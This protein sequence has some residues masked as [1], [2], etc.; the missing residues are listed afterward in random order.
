MTKITESARG[1]E[2]QFRIPGVCNRNPETTV[3]CHDSGAGFG[4]KWADT[5]GGYGCSACHDLIDGR[6][7]Y[8]HNGHLV[9]TPDDIELMFYQGCRRTRQI[10]IKKGLI[11]LS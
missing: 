11:K 3:F 7:K 5:E 9:Y 10:L 1:E 4:I 2:C 8:K 6:S